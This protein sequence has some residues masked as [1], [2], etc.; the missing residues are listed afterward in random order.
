MSDITE[1]KE[2]LKKL[3][4]EYRAKVFESCEVSKQITETL[5]NYYTKEKLQTFNN[6]MEFL[7]DI[8]EFCV[9]GGSGK[10]KFI[11]EIHDVYEN[12]NFSFQFNLKQ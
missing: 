9:E 4:I 1:V 11:S 2:R 12:N 3:T 8:N 7:D 5:R 10:L 6:I